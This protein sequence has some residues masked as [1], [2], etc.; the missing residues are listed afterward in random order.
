MSGIFGSLFNAH[1]IPGS[2]TPVFNP[3][4]QSMLPALE[5]FIAPVFEQTK[6]DLLDRIVGDVPPTAASHY[7]Q[8]F[9]GLTDQQVK[10]LWAASL[11]TAADVASHKR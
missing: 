2:P 1:P 7:A 11:L 6:L 9:K 8:V 5:S 10:A 4:L 3:L